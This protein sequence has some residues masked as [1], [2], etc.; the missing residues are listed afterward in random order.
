MSLNGKRHRRIISDNGSERSK[1]NDHIGASRSVFDDGHE[2]SSKY[3][4]PNSGFLYGHKTMS[5][6]CLTSIRPAIRT[7]SCNLDSGDRDEGL[8]GAGLFRNIKQ[9]SFLAGINTGSDED[10][11]TPES[12]SSDDGDTIAQHAQRSSALGPQSSND[13]DDDDTVADDGGDMFD[14][15]A[16]ISTSGLTHL[17]TNNLPSFNSTSALSHFNAFQG[18]ALRAIQSVDSSQFDYPVSSFKPPAIIAVSSL[19]MPAT[20]N[21]N[22][23][24]SSSSSNNNSNSNSNIA[25]TV[26][27]SKSIRSVVTTNSIVDKGNDSTDSENSNS[28]KS[29]TNDGNNDNNKLIINND[30]DSTLTGGKQPMHAPTAS[31]PNPSAPSNSFKRLSVGMPARRPS[32]LQIGSADPFKHQHHHRNSSSSGTLNLSERAVDF[33]FDSDGYNANDEEEGSDWFPNSP[34][35]GISPSSI[36]K[37]LSFL[38]VTSF[39]AFASAPLYDAEGAERRVAK[40]R[41]ERRRREAGTEEFSRLRTMFTK[42]AVATLISKAVKAKRVNGVLKK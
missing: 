34:S 41:K 12:V 5:H 39:S 32:P 31:R 6:G 14:H 8:S 1:D 15:F 28:S 17:R 37:P 26:M 30:S 29:P 9:Q 40:L 33:V 25:A 16:D 13:K 38:R 36:P 21:N 42:N 24:S 10:K 35:S 11:S 4:G 2:E 3:L 22:N 23:S 20:S 19:P 27:P 18:K 7:S